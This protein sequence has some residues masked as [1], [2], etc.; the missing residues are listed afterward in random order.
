MK[1]EKRSKGLCYFCCEKYMSGH[2]CKNSKHLYLLELEE[3][4]ELHDPVEE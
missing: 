1:I 3:T 2:K 4:D